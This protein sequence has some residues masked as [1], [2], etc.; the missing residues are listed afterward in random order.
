[1]RNFT[2]VS[3]EWWV[4][5]LIA[6][7][8]FV[9][10]APVWADECADA[11]QA[12]AAAEGKL[13]AKQDALQQADAKEAKAKAALKTA[14][15]A[16]QEALDAFSDAYF[17]GIKAFTAELKAWNNT[18]IGSEFFNTEAWQ[19]YK[20]AEAVTNKARA[21]SDKAKTQLDAAQKAWESANGLWWKAVQE[22]IKAEKAVE[23]QEKLVEEAKQYVEEACKSETP[24]LEK[25]LD[26]FGMND[27]SGV[28]QEY[29][30]RAQNAN[31]EDIAIQNAVRRGLD[32]DDDDGGAT[33]G[34]TGGTTA[35]SGSVNC[36]GGGG[37]TASV[38]INAIS[39]C[40]AVNT[41][42]L[43]Q[44]F[45]LNL[46]PGQVFLM[47]LACSA[48]GSCQMDL[49]LAFIGA[50]CAGLNPGGS[51]NVG[52]GSQTSVTCTAN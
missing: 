13:K 21:V 9:S 52:G 22:K 5:G 12:L 16:R 45:N 3:G 25:L 6:M 1:M 8:L 10:V 2:S 48:G 19:A 27:G 17:D 36:F 39:V 14:A 29:A 37:S 51:L 41:L 31:T 30:G 20:A 4:A 15:A 11:K 50:I 35:V 43:N 18:G 44:T 38:L 24:E 32:V 34:G 26:G 47:T 40:V 46:T 49:A 28:I 33:G 23:A 7:F 42:V